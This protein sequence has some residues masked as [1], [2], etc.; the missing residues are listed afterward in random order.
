MN[1]CTDSLTGSPSFTIEVKE[2]EGGYE[3][4]S[5]NAIVPACRAADQGDAIR[6]FSF[7]LYEALAKGE[8]IATDQPYDG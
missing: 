3:A 5:P 2:V 4:F 6:A 7:A 1:I 8:A